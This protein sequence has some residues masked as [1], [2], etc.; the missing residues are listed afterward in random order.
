MVTISVIIP[1]YN[2]ERFLKQSIENVLSQSFNNIEIILIDDGSIDNSSKIINQYAS[3]NEKILAIH[4]A[5]AGVS[6][7][8]NARIENQASGFIF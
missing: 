7:A 3:H 1:I 8:R 4:Q 5:N 2:A 6:K